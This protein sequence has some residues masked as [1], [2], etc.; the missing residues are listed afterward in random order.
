MRDYLEEYNDEQDYSYQKFYTE[1]EYES[2]A[3]ISNINEND[4]LSV[5]NNDKPKRKRKKNNTIE[6][7]KTP[8]V[9]SS[10]DIV[11]YRK[12]QAIVLIGP[13]EKNFK[14]YYEIQIHD[15]SIV[16]ATASALS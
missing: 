8:S 6:T 9:F 11:T 14:Q 5:T 12:K 10:G 13:Y 1:E 15:G 16:T 7:K 3:D 4:F 2:G